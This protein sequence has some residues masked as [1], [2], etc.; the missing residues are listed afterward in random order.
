MATPKRRVLILCT[1]NSARSQ[2]AE[3][4]LRSL[5]QN[6]LEVHSAGTHP[7]GLNPLAVEVMKEI[8]ID[9]SSQRSKSVDE[10]ARQTFDT[11]I[12]VCDNAKQECPV[13]SG[14]PRMIH[15]SLE[16]PA[17]VQG[18]RKRKLAAFRHTRDELSA[19][20]L[21]FVREQSLP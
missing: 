13:F 11:V 15:F 4:L 20:L 6:T 1:G 3:G 16:D 5:S 9:I 17:T 7:V 10:F 14:A 8:Q 18:T 2:M 12:T 19:R 21:S